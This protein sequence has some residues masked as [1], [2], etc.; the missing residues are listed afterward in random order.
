MD[1]E[2]LSISVRFTH[3]PV[4]LKQLRDQV[5]EQ[6]ECTYLKFLMSQTQN[7]LDSVGRLSGLSKP[8]IY[9]LLKKYDISKS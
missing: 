9:A 5:T 2:I 3:P 7:D 1:K 4:T 8:R 6:L